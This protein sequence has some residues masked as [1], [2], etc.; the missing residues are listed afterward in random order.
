MK[1]ISN[2]NYNSQTFWVVIWNHLIWNHTQHCQR[3]ITTFMCQYRPTRTQ[4]SFLCLTLQPQMPSRPI[5]F[6]VH[7]RNKTWSPAPWPR[8]QCL[9][10]RCICTLTPVTMTKRK[11]QD[12]WSLHFRF[13]LF[14]S[15]KK[16]IFTI[17][18]IQFQIC[19]QK[20]KCRKID[21]N[22]Y[23]KFLEFLFHF[24]FVSLIN[25]IHLL[26]CSWELLFSG[27]N[28][29]ETSSLPIRPTQLYISSPSL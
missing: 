10:A 21:N 11:A 17:L 15:K 13:C 7:T 22:F 14:S 24:T 23:T 16:T 12:E 29:H 3:R 6:P 4:V 2:Q 25:L 27:F 18:G 19:K 9:S 20:Q 26:C 5:N 28:Y 1:Q 8:D